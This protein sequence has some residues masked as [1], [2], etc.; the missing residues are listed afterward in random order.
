MLSRAESAVT[1]TRM[2]RNSLLNVD[3]NVALR[4]LDGRRMSDDPAAYKHRI[5]YVPEE[6]HL[7]THLTPSEYLMLVGRLRGLTERALSEKVPGF[8]HLLLLWES[9]YATM[10]AYSKGTSRPGD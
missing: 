1:T 5:G 3:P 6:P 2:R 4:W 10:A 7:Y 9:R 8:L